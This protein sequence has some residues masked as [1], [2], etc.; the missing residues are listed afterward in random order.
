MHPAAE[1]AYRLKMVEG[2]AGN[3]LDQMPVW[4]NP[5]ED[6]YTEIL[7]EKKETIQKALTEL[8][9]HPSMNK[10]LHKYLNIIYKG[11]ET[12]KLL[13]EQWKRIASQNKMVASDKLDNLEKTMQ[14]M[15]KEL[16]KAVPSVE[17]LAGGWVK[18]RFIVPALYREGAGKGEERWTEER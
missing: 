17:E 15:K 12:G 11:D 8:E 5:L 2:L 13:F 9:M 18:M 10:D 6:R 4:E 7:R 16:E 14:R 1:I 3:V